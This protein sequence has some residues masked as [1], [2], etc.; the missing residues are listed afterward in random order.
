[1]L[2]RR[3]TQWLDYS[4]FPVRYAM[5]DN[6]LIYAQCAHVARWH[7]A[8]AGRMQAAA[9][10]CR[11]AF[12][13][14]SVSVSSACSP[15]LFIPDRDASGQWRSEKQMFQLCDRRAA[16]PRFLFL[17]QEAKRSQPSFDAA[18]RSTTIGSNVV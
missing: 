9:G 16:H 6:F 1:M 15:S 17:L 2:V 14:G 3:G 13:D 12:T 11:A 4:I 18:Q 7:Y 5:Q 10:L 8:Q